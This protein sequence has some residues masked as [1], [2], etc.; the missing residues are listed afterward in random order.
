MTE[1]MFV[2]LRDENM[3]ERLK[4]LGENNKTSVVP[5]VYEYSLSS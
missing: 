1:I 2:W 3:R 5:E 4:R